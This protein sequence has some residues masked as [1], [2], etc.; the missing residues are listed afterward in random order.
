MNKPGQVQDVSPATDGD[1]RLREILGGS[2]H[3]VYRANL[4]TGAYDYVSADAERLYERCGWQRVGRVPRYALLPGGAFCSTVFYF[5]D[6]ALAG[7]GAGV[8]NPS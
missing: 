1:A 6:L 7:A 2:G 3:L 4:R 5:K 8:N